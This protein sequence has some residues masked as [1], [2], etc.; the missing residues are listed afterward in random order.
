MSW[1]W[2][3]KNWQLSPPTL[4]R[5]AQEM[6]GAIGCFVFKTLTIIKKACGLLIKALK[7][8]SSLQ[9]TN[10]HNALL[11]E[12]SWNFKPKSRIHCPSIISLICGLPACIP[13]V[14]SII[15]LLTG[16]L[17]LLLNT[18]FSHRGLFTLTIT[19]NPL[20]TDFSKAS[21]A[22]T[23]CF[24]LTNTY[25]HNL[26]KFCRNFLALTNKNYGCI[27]LLIKKKNVLI[28][29]NVIPCPFSL[30]IYRLLVKYTNKCILS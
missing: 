23:F 21:Y 18:E 2:N 17:A 13:E 16:D 24:F 22:C 20:L 7:G 1:V 6:K 3:S 30:F 14:T 15:I 9:I 19:F 12:L 27:N 5:S 4:L 10:S 25:L 8:W 29:F 28:I 11:S 26:Y